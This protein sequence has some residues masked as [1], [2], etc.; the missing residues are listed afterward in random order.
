MK[1]IALGVGVT[2]AVVLV[3]HLFLLGGALAYTGI[4]VHNKVTGNGKAQS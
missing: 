2:A 1:H 4:A 3:P